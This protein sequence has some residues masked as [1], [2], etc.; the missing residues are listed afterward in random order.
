MYT[1]GFFGQFGCSAMPSA[2]RSPLPSTCVIV[3][4][5][6]SRWFF[7]FRMW[8]WPVPRSRY[9]IF[10]PGANVNPATPFSPVL[11]GWEATALPTRICGAGPRAT[12]E[13]ARAVTRTRQ[14]AA[15]RTRIVRIDLLPERS[16]SVGCGSMSAVSVPPST[17]GI[18]ALRTE[19]PRFLRGEG[20]YLENIEVP[21]S[22]R[23]VF[24]RSIFPH[25][26]L[27]SV[28]GSEDARAMPGVAAV[29]TASELQI[30]PQ[31]PSGNVEVP[32]G[33]LD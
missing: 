16:R 25:A 23:A 28:E 5:R 24:V 22:L 18:P 10:P 19:D 33:D 12:A 9:Q 11:T 29:Y 26:E 8:T 6:W 20:R 7:G 21:G 32:G 27:R 4:N 30:P 14:L 15:V 13:D 2:P 1:N 31:P 3:K 17:F